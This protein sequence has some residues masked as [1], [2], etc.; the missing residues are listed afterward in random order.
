MYPVS[1]LISKSVRIYLQNRFF[2]TIFKTLF[3]KIYGKQNKYS[4]I[5]SGQSIY[6]DRTLSTLQSSQ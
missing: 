6:V 5:N 1:V 3:Q 4:D 2:S